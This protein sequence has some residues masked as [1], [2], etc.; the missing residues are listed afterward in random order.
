[1]LY[2][3]GLAIHSPGGV[4]F[5]IIIVPYSPCFVLSKSCGL[6]IVPQEHN[7]EFGFHTVHSLCLPVLDREQ[8]GLFATWSQEPMIRSS[9]YLILERRSREVATL[10]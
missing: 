4:I 10:L 7:S 9:S 8:R 2:V 1:M 6:E 5:G 3:I